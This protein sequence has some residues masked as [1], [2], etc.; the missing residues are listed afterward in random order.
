MRD[1]EQELDVTLFRRSGRCLTL[2]NAGKTVVESARFA[3]DAVDDVAQTARRAGFASELV[4][5]TT[6]T[7]SILL[8]PIV[9]SFA[10]QCA[11]TTVRLCRAD[12]MDEVVAMVASREA[13]LGFGEIDNRDDTDTLQC[14]P[15]WNATVVVVSPIDADLP[16]PVPL[17]SLATSRLVLPPPGSG[18]RKRIDELFTSTYGRAPSPVFETDE[19]SAWTSCA[20]RSVGS[21]F[22][23]QAASTELHDVVL[24]PIDPPLEVAVG[25]IARRDSTSAESDT[26]RHLA[27]QCTPP[28]GCERLSH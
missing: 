22:S 20:Q 17:A 18:R 23:Y 26:L 6:P 15:L 25:F 28:L 14:T 9:T 12:D 8:S 5:A 27:V 2:T 4:V 16:V 21:Y 7:N 24:T 11:Q 19:R 3:L 10:K 1:L 13:E